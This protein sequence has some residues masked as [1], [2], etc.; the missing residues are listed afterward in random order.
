M[1]PPVQDPQDPPARKSGQPVAAADVPDP[2]SSSDQPVAASVRHL[3]AQTK[4]LPAMRPPATLRGTVAR[5]AAREAASRSESRP[6]SL[7]ILRARGQPVAATEIRDGNASTPRR[8][9]Q[10]F[11][12]EHPPTN[13]GVPQ[14]D[15]MINITELINGF[16]GKAPSKDAMQLEGT[17]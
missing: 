11:F 2:S 6:A 3:C 9:L 15:G 12:C 13:E 8:K 1:P 14:V 17:G 4:S 7:C 16:L 10:E 5:E